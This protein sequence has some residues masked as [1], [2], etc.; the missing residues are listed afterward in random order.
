MTT[1]ELIPEG[2][3]SVVETERIAAPAQ[4]EQGALFRAVARASP[5]FGRKKVPRVF[6][7][8]SKN[9]RLFWAWL[10]FASRLMPYGRLPAR[11][12][13][14][15]ILRTA[16]NTR[17][18]YEWGQHVELGL[19][20]GVTDDDILRV[21]RGPAAFDDRHERTLMQACDDVF[22]RSIVAEATWAALGE[23]YDEPLLIELV[24]LIGHYIML[25]GL[26]NTSGIGLEPDI[27][28]VLQAFHARVADT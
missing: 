7:V 26:L 2:G 8:L 3:W 27:E 6:A 14:K 23:R 17:S 18:R 11:E 25:A 15:V 13:E 10:F 1:R 16:W 21:A 19:A 5:W 9:P 24:V 22:A 12:R 4:D 20:V 28:A